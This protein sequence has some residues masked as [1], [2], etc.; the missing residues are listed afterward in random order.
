MQQDEQAEDGL[1]KEWTWLLQ[2][3]MTNLET[4]ALGK[5]TL[6]CSSDD[7]SLLR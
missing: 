6:A 7:Y 5:Y 4:W 1:K 2:N 3:S